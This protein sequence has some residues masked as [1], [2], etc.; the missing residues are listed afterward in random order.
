M[1]MLD[2]TPPADHDFSHEV[3]EAHDLQ[4][5]LLRYKALIH[6]SHQKHG[7]RVRVIKDALHGLSQGRLE[8]A[9]EIVEELNISY[10]GNR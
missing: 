3:G 7:H 6:R 5:E 9:W 8:E 10:K 2:F 4:R 1:V